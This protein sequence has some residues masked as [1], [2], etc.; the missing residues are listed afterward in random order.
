MRIAVVDYDLCRPDKCSMEC[1]KVCPLNMRGK[2]C[3]VMADVPVAGQLKKKAKI[4]ESLCIGCGLCVKACPFHAIKIVNTPEKLKEGPVHRYGP[5]GFLLFRLPV[6]K[7]G[8]VGILGENGLGKSTAM[9]ILA[10]ELKPNLGKED[11]GWD[12]IVKL[13]RG[14]ELQSYFSELAEG[15]IKA[16][17]KPQRIDAVQRVMKGKDVSELLK[18]VEPGLVDRFGL[19]DLGSRKIEQLSGGELQ[20][21]MIAAALSRKAGLYLIDE[22]SSYLDVRQRL[23]M[24]KAIREKSSESRVM[25]I[26]HDLATLDMLS[27]YIHI[28]YG[29]PGA[30]GV[31]SKNYSAR[32]GINA[33]IDGYI[34]EDNVRIHEP[35][36]FRPVIRESQPRKTVLFHVPDVSVDYPSFSLRTQGFD[37][38][39]SEVIGIVGENGM[40]KTTFMEKLASMD[41][42]VSYKPQ[43]IRPAEGTVSELLG[44]MT[45]EQE[46]MI[47]RPMSVMELMEKQ[48][49]DL[50]GGELQ[51]VMVAKALM[52][53]ADIYLLDE[54]C[55]FLDVR[56]R[57]ALAK[58]VTD[59]ASRKALVVIE[60]D[61]MLI[62]HISDRLMVFQGQPGVHGEASI[63]SLQEGMNLFL[64]SI[65]V[66]F[67]MDKQTRRPRPNKPGSQKDAEQREKGIYYEA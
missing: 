57:L 27:D 6:P 54:P 19:S 17:Y 45:Q 48:L 22:P 31:V 25:V 33:F 63:H 61:L 3:V 30:F 29:V 51:R 13:H 18:S 11:A 35:I 66:T 9:K 2:Q 34:K 24:A 43:F 23:E 16:V 10:G 7:P 60:H 8:V 26:E 36:K 12:E 20:K 50:S 46:I 1:M 62:S 65:G 32:N 42:A 37:I 47:A 40:G 28:F 58:V 39:E 59:I 4:D 49:S 67:R 52:Q 56:Q 21:L 38:H 41:I 14:S 64:K 15:K 53:D 5:N 44:S 55:A